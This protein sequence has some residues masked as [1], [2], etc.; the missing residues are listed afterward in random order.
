MPSEFA[1]ITDFTKENSWIQS[2]RKLSA[3]LCRMAVRCLG[4]TTVF[5]TWLLK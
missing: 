2:A 1:V 3:M 5:L 4:Q